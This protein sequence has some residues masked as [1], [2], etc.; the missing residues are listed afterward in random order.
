MLKVF[1]GYWYS[2]WDHNLWCQ[3]SW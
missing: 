3:V 1:L 2:T